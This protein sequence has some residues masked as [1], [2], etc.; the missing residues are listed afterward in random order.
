MSLS[1]KVKLLR[2]GLR[3]LPC[4]LFEVVVVVVVVV[5]E[6]LSLDYFLGHL[7]LYPSLLKLLSGLEISGIQRQYVVVFRAAEEMD[8]LDEALRGT[9]KKLWPIE[10]KK[11][12]N[13]LIPHNEGNG[14]RFREFTDV[15]MKSYSSLG[16]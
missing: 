15:K 16:E 8:K 13:M 9:I 1:F 3:G 6:L 14:G 11:M 7:A 12:H 5:V 10:G 2:C 4:P